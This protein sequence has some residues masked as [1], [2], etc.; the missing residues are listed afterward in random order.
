MDIQEIRESLENSKRLLQKIQADLLWRQPERVTEFPKTNLSDYSLTSSV[1][2]YTTIIS[3][4]EAYLDNHGDNYL[5]MGYLNKNQADTFC[6]IILEI[7]DWNIN[8]SVTILDFGCGT[9]HLYEYIIENNLAENIHYSGLDILEK[10]INISKL[11]FP[12]NQYYCLDILDQEANLPEFDY[13]T[14]NGV[15]TAKFSLSFEE[16][17]SYFEILVPQVFNF[18]KKGISFNVFCPHTQECYSDLLFYLPFDELGSF[19]AKKVSKNFTIRNDYN[20]EDYT[21]YVYK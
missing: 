2:A 7:V 16:M 15:F 1:P 6:K 21:V 11:K 19:L 18:C 17:K 14:M 20:L 10:S 12:H 13:I 8:S 3:A 4:C 5:G 9:S